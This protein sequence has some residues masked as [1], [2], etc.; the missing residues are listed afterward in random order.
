MN[1]PNFADVLVD[2]CDQMHDHMEFP[3]YMDADVIL[4]G[5]VP[6]ACRTCDGRWAAINPCPDCPTVADLLRMGFEA[7]DRI[8]ELEAENARLRRDVE[9]VQN[10]DWC[11]A[12]SENAR[13][14]AE[15]ARLTAELE[16]RQ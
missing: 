2:I 14:R 13:L 16:A 15:V 1:A 10:H 6:G 7:A 12:A 8:T 11:G 9:I 4:A 5:R 3:S